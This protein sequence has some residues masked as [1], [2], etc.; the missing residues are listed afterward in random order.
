[1]RS[2]SAWAAILFLAAMAL[3]PA[4]GA[5][6]GGGACDWPRKEFAAGA[7]IGLVT[8]NDAAI[9]NIAFDAEPAVDPAS[10]ADGTVRL[11]DDANGRISASPGV[12]FRD[13]SDTFDTG[14]ARIAVPRDT[15]LNTAKF[16]IEGNKLKTRTVSI[17]L[18]R[19][20]PVDVRLLDKA[21]LSRS[22]DFAHDDLR[23]ARLPSARQP[24]TIEAKAVKLDAKFAD[25]K[26]HS[27]ACI[28]LDG[29]WRAQPLERIENVTDDSADLMI[30]IPP[31]RFLDGFAYPKLAVNLGDGQYFGKAEFRIYPRW[32]GAVAAIALVILGHFWIWGLA[33][34][35]KKT[36]VRD[37]LKNGSLGKFAQAWFSGVDRVPSL[38]MFQIYLW[39][40]VVIAGLTYVV[41]LTGQLFAITTQVLALLGIAGLGSIAAR[42]VAAA[43]GQRQAAPGLAENPKFS[44]IL[45]TNGEFDLYKLQMFLFTVYTAGYVAIRIALDQAFPVI[46]SNL[47]LLMGISNGIYVG[48]RA[49]SGESP[50]AAA[51]RLDAQFRLLTEARQNA[52]AEAA[53]LTAGKAAIDAALTAKPDDA[54]LK[55][56]KITNDRLL[57]EA[58]ARAADLTKQLEDAVVARK[59]A[60]DRLSK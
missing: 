7:P 4:A 8:P 13:G 53:Q 27:A 33:I 35:T 43:Q 40:W 50:Y 20:Q 6:A 11:L 57:A 23:P 16:R 30:A 48:S 42:F 36:R 5:Q 17:P 15:V 37:L 31:G 47:L 46:D 19:D 34:D 14:R 59:T 39:T 24:G 18:T 44:D 2:L 22:V 9:V 21:A 51:E 38:S 54:D 12:Y 56:K 58:D 29:Q 32:F 3:A 45:K 55:L 28:Y 10:A 1:M 26:S 25:L 52:D 49:A 60:I 41:A